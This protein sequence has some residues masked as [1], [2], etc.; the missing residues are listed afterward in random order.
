[1]TAAIVGPAL[2]ACANGGPSTVP[3][4]P[5]G[6]P[7]D[8]AYAAD[9]WQ[10]L[11]DARLAGSEAIQSKPYPGLRP[12]GAILQNL[13]ARLTVDDRAGAVIVLR[14]FRGA[15]VSIDA[16][17]QNPDRYLD[18]IAVMFLRTG[19]DPE[20]N[21]W[22]WAR[23]RPD[24]TLDTDD[25]GRRLAGRVGDPEAGCIACHSAAP[26]GDRVFT[27]DRFAR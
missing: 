17:A 7:Q 25:R 12:H 15:G 3:P 22:F 4:T 11:T 8:I 14:N 9:L 19:Y 20:N 13:D 10:A 16:V 21:D 1:M 23:Y 2:T 27:H 18:T 24:G 5:F 26:G 6:S